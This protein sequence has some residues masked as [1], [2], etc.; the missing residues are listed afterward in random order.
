MNLTLFIRL[1]ILHY[2]LMKVYKSFYKP[3]LIDLFMLR[4]IHNKIKI[5][6]PSRNVNFICYFPNFSISFQR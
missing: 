1:I 2:R 6:Y 5:N 4:A 3:I